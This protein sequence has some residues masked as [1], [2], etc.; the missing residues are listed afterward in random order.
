MNIID[1]II[2]NPEGTVI[3][4]S[5]IQKICLDKLK[6]SPVPNKKSEIWRLT[7]KTK[8]ERFLN[9]QLSN[10]FYNPKIPKDFKKQ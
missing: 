10:E 7:N 8:F 5:K 2:Q 1:Q 4:K 9:Y 3:A 6:E